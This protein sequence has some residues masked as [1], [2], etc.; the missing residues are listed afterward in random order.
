MDWESFRDSGS[1]A[2]L[3]DAGP[4]RDGESSPIDGALQDSSDSTDT[5]AAVLTP[6]CSRGTHKVCV[7]FDNGTDPLDL[8]THLSGA[9]T[10][11]VDN[12]SAV[13]PPSSL[14]VRVPSGQ[15]EY[16]AAA[17]SAFSLASTINVAGTV[18]AR[19]AIRV[20]STPDDNSLLVLR[21]QLSLGTTGKAR[22]LGF[23]LSKSPGSSNLAVEIVEQDELATNIAEHSTQ[24]KVALGAWSILELSLVD[25]AKVRATI[26]GAVV[27]DEALIGTDWA[28]AVNVLQAYVG[29]WYTKP[30]SPVVIRV[31]DF[32]VDW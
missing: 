21:I 30:P 27:I 9:S 15:S 32:A 26:D 8:G 4:N 11:Q 7:G 2:S 5:D 14:V 28:S 25:H 29:C 16:T 17:A 6:F 13:S 1:T 31:D 23:V 10:A 22:V 18:T 12:A 3:T 19:A 24:A 20:D